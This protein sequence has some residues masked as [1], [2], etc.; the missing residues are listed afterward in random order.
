MSKTIVQGFATGAAMVAATTLVLAH[1]EPFGYL[2]GA[3]T[4]AK[5]EWE[6]TQWTTGRIGK[7][8]GRYLGMEFNTELEYGIT[9]RLQTALYLSEQYHFS[10][11]AEG[12]SEEIE[13]R[14]SVGFSG[15]STEF[16]YQLQS[17]FSHPWGFAVYVEPGWNRIERVS[18]ERAD[19]IELETIFIAQ[20]N[21]LGN[22]LI[23]VFNYTLE[24]EWERE[25]DESNFKTNLKMRWSVGASYRITDHWALGVESRLEGEFADADLN[26]ANYLVLHAGPNISYSKGRFFGTFTVLPQIIGWPNVR[27]TG[28]LELDEH[29]R[30][31]LRL[32]MGTEF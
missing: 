6:V 18:G 4:E 31:E 1:E 29:E 5:G 17:P 28:G 12:S 10:R 20:R 7:E 8:K 2:K 32:K 27:R 22:R 11:G 26:R 23:T 13:D 3:Q 14:D 9:D 21:F 19:E 30:L 15:I 16:K 25:G 24:P